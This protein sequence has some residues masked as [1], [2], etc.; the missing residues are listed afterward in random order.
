VLV[1]NQPNAAVITTTEAKRDLPGAFKVAEQKR[2]YVT[3][4]GKP[5]GALISME[6]MQL[7]E[8]ALKEHEK[9]L[10]RK[11]HRTGRVITREQDEEPN[12]LRLPL[13]ERIGAVREI[14]RTAYAFKK[15]G[16]NA[17]A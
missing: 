4:D 14:T 11:R 15:A 10:E 16:E 8:Q 17:G 1:I 7:L 6:M 12:T 9:Y 13:A 3:K 5:I 2:V